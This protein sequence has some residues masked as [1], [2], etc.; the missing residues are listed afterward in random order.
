MQATIAKWGNS[1]ALRLPRHITEQ[2]KLSD[3]SAVELTVD[4]DGALRIVPT[5]RKLALD[6]LLDGEPERAP[7]GTSRETDWGTPR[8]GEPW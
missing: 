1:L 6:E 3:G 2:T 5:R 8:G 7:E 4:A